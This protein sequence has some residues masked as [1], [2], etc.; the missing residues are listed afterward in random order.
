[1]IYDRRKRNYETSH[2]EEAPEKKDV[3]SRVISCPRCGKAIRKGE[4]HNCEKKE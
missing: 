2:Y 4:S 1:M 3:T